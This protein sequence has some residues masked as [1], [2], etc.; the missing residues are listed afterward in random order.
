MTVIDA[1]LTLLALLLQP[2]LGAR[3]RT[4][5]ATDRCLFGCGASKGKGVYEGEWLS[6]HFAPGS[7][8]GLCFNQ[9]EIVSGKSLFGSKSCDRVLEGSRKVSKTKTVAGRDVKLCCTSQE[10]QSKC[11]FPFGDDTVIEEAADKIN[12]DNSIKFEF[13]KGENVDYKLPSGYCVRDCRSVKSSEKGLANEA[14]YQ[15]GCGTS[16]ELSSHVAI[17][18]AQSSY[19]DIFG[20]LCCIPILASKEEQN[21]VQTKQ[22][23]PPARAGEEMPAKPH[24]DV[25]T[26][27]TVAVNVPSAREEEEMPNKP[28]KH[29]DDEDPFDT[30]V[31]I[32]KQKPKV[33][34]PSPPEEEKSQVS[35]RREMPDE[36]PDEDSEDDEDPFD[37]YQERNSKQIQVKQLYSSLI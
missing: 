34:S 20:K 21:S 1:V 14:V 13:G 29:E 31:D 9:C 3:T 35:G 17:A 4:N 12:T 30:Y 25:Q 19:G 8:H 16:K 2:A 18:T 27:Q 33:Y 32:T 28:D 15:K 23:V 24:E 26:K 10:C 11:Q 5:L 6:F 7:T 36:I 37:A 22:R